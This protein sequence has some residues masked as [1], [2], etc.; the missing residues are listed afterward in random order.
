MRRMTTPGDPDAIAR[1]ARQAL[2]LAGLRNRAATV[3]PGGSSNEDLGGYRVTTGRGEVRVDWLPAD[4]L[5][6]EAMS[7]RRHPTHPLVA[8]DAE[9]RAVMERAIAGVLHAAG[10]TVTLRPARRDVDEM[11]EAGIP[12]IIVT[13]APA[14]RVWA[15]D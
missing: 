7:S 6:E 1:L 3:G 11:D 5:A 10:F 12:A 14:I 15:T 4:P 2:T 13:A 9:V 8:F